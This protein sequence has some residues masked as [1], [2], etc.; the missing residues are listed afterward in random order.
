MSVETLIYSALKSLVPGEHVYRDIAPPE[1]PLP[2]IVFQ[3]VGGVALN[4]LD[5]ATKPTKKNGRF[6]VTV[7]GTRRDD[8]MALARQVEDTLRATGPLYTTVMGAAI[9]TFE[10]AADEDSDDLYGSIQDFSFWY[11]D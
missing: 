8:V 7:W 1:T 3:Q 4:F 5:S 9:A 6:Q 11:D 2:R 10:P